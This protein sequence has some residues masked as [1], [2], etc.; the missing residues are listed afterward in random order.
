[1]YLIQQFAKLAGVTVR[2]LHHYDRLGLLSPK[3]RTESGYRLYTTDDLVRLERIMV[4][5]YLGLS[6]R[7]I[8]DLLSAVNLDDQTIAE[9]LQ[10]QAIVLRERRASITRVIQAVEAAERSLDASHTPDWQLFKSIIQEISMQDTVEWQKKYYSDSA[11]KVVE[12]RASLWTPQLQEQYTRQ[13]NELFAKVETAVASGVDPASPNGKQLAAEWQNLVEGF[14]GGNPEVQ[15][16]LNAMYNDQAN[17]PEAKKQQHTMN[18]E[19]ME[20]IRKASR[21]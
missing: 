12:E 16:G 18:P 19:V 17:W 2:T 15:K 11:Q 3:Q 1:M 4:L 5:R 20:F 10:T 13:W 9:L 7:Q 14:T 8:A 21:P 6:L